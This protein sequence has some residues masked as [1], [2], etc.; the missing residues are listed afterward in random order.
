MTI[1]INELIIK[2]KIDND[3]DVP[4]KE[5]A[6]VSRSDKDA[7]AEKTAELMSLNKINRER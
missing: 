5:S 3:N 1:K 7:D 2:A 6:P 4:T